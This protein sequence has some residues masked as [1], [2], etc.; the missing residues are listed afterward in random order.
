[1]A[2]P[3]LYVKEEGGVG[4]GDKKKKEKK[5]SEAEAEV[6]SHYFGEYVTDPQVCARAG[7]QSDALSQFAMGVSLIVDNSM[8]LGGKRRT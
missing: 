5:T 8:I 4:G 1:V 6:H 2:I 3:I 7:I